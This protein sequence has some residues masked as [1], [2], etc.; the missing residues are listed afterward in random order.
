M[1]RPEAALPDA[2]A[3]RRARAKVE[4]RQALIAATIDS[5]AL[6]GL[7]GTTMARVTE[8]AGTSV[9]LANFH[10]DNKE[11]LFEA[12]LE[13][14]AG[15]E[16]ALWAAVSRQA[17]AAPADRLAALI[18]ARFDATVCNPRTLGVWFAFWGDAGARS[19]YRRAVEAADNA[20]LA[21]VADLIRQLDPDQTA[22]EVERIALGI[23]GFCDGLWLNHLLYPE[24]FDRTTCR[25]SAIRH[26]TAVFP[27]RFD[28]LD[29]GA[30]RPAGAACAKDLP[31]AP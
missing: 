1:T 17:P 20:R 22:E 23:E 3:S 15:I 12:V 27:T 26:L 7:S 21:A 18:G 11:R 8:R 4:R 6:H 28:G 31:D 16:Q 14:L 25:D 13:H 9:G 10:F 19:I 29:A 24:D 2:L 5:I 30:L